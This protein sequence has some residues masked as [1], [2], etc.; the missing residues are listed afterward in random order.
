[1]TTWRWSEQIVPRT[2]VECRG[3][4][5]TNWTRAEF[6]GRPPAETQPT[7]PSWAGAPG[8]NCDVKG[9]LATKPPPS[10]RHCVDRSTGSSARVRHP[11]QDQESQNS[12]LGELFCA[13]VGE[14]AVAPMCE[15]DDVPYCAP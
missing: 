1:M 10:V 15:S 6:G 9:S 8:V 12:D 5:P 14:Y 11:H 3:D 7:D 4:V 13:Y 2:S